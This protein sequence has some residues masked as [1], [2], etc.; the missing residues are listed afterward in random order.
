MGFLIK[1]RI[2]EDEPPGIGL[3]GNQLGTIDMVFLGFYSIFLSISGMIAD[4]YS[5]RFLLSFSFFMI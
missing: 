3:S 4:R 5:K 1:D 2:S